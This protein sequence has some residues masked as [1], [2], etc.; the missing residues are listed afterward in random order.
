MTLSKWADLHR[1]DL[2]P[3]QSNKSMIDELRAVADREIR[4]AETVESSDGRLG[5]AHSACL[6]VAAAALAAIG[7]SRAAWLVGPPLASDRVSAIHGGPD[8]GTSQ[9]TAGLPKE[10]QSVYLRARWHH[11]EH[12]GQCCSH[13]R[14][15]PSRATR[16]LAGSGAPQAR[17]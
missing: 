4:D 7:I 16:C 9:G 2:V 6:A 15:S 8:G 14:A 13:R 11:H 17:V 1:S 12:R 5:H 10:A 3:E